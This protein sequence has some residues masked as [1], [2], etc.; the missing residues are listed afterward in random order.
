L[1]RSLACLA[2]A[3]L[4]ASGCGRELPP[5]V[6]LVSVDTLR[7][8]ALGSYGGPLPTP[9]FDR[10]AREGVVFE[11]AFAPTPATAASHATLF[12][13]QE[14]QRHGLLRNGESLDAAATTL[15]ERLAAAGWQT[16]AFVSSFVLDPRFGFG[17]GFAHYDATLPESGATM[18]KGKPYPGAFWAAER[19]GGF[20]RRATATT[21]AARRWIETAPEPFFAFVHYFDPHAPY[22]PPPVFADRADAATPSLVNRRVPGI[23]PDVLARLIRRY[24]GEVLY[25]DDALAALLDVASR[26]ERPTL[27]VVTADH[28]EGLGQHEWLEH[29]VHLYE[30][31]LHVP[32]ILHG[33]PGLAAGRRVATPVA[34]A[35]VAPTLLELLG[36]PNG[37]AIDGRSLAAAARGGPEPEARPL[38]GVRRLVSED[39]AWDRGVELSVRD[40]R[41]KYIWDSEAAAELYDLSTDPGELRDVAAERGEVAAELRARLE[42]HVAA[43][44]ALRDAAPLSDETREALRAL[45]Y[46]E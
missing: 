41:W 3:C 29:A 46:V 11:R 16:A 32:L 7:A 35:D 17:Q 43:L 10:L 21:D 37:D 12:T 19:F 25:T 24:W 30:E 45:G 6:L 8:D 33:L 42:R 34:L 18:G 22:L 36:V 44:P 5:N 2:L 40:E 1:K 14:P 23:E 26:R 4:A 20:D 39:V 15:A 9:S 38:F 28:G 13:G 27:V 31:Q